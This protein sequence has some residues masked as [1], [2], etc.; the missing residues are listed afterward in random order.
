MA[1]WRTPCFDCGLYMDASLDADIREL[2]GRGR[3]V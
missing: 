2:Y 1:S 3:V